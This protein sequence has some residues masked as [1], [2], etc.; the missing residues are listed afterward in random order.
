VPVCLSPAH[1]KKTSW[2]KVFFSTELRIGFYVELKQKDDL[3]YLE[4]LKL[5]IKQKRLS[6]IGKE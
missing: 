4:L 5:Y 3:D 6:E 2:Q 1:K